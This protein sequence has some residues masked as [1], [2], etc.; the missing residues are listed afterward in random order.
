[1]L[2]LN[3]ID[4]KMKKGMHMY[5]LLEIPRKTARIPRIIAHKLPIRCVNTFITTVKQT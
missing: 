2:Q 4:S 3:T 1:M 5:D